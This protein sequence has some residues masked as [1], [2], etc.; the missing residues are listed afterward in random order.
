MKKLKLFALGLIGVSA[1]TLTSCADDTTDPAAKAP[2]FISLTE[3][4]V[5][6]EN[7]V[8]EVTAGAAVNFIWEVRKGDASMDKFEVLVN[9]S[10]ITGTSDGGY[11]FGS[12]LS[13]SNEDLYEDSYSF[14]APSSMVSSEYTFRITDEDGLVDEETVTLKVVAGTT[15]LSAA[16]SFTWQRQGSNDGT[17]LAQFGLEWT[18][19][20]TVGG[21]EVMAIVAK[22]AAT[23][24]V[25]LQSSD[26]NDITTVQDLSAAITAGTE[27]TEYTEVS[28]ENDNATY[29]DVLGVMH[30]GSVYL[31]HITNGDVATDPTTGT[32]VTITGEY[33]TNP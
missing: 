18:E 15:N 7:D 13:G 19:N 27:I 21:T 33:K 5:G 28:A 3:G 24:M 11:E 30:N 20:R 32:T 17:G 12:D 9:G 22:D 31:L 16:Q 29:D 8:V 1:L 23:S 14:S 4:N 26:W 2:L 10:A 25:M 6:I